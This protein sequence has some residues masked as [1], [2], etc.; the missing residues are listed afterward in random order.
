MTYSNKFEEE[1]EEEK[2][3]Y[4]FISRYSEIS[5]RKTKTK[6]LILLGLEDKEQKKM[7]LGSFFF[8]LLK[9]ITY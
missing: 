3:T 4:R 2:N 6:F 7:Y 5:T 8:L 9:K 1:E